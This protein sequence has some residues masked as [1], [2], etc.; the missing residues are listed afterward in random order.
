VLWKALPEQNPTKL[1]STQNTIPTANDDF[2]K[3]NYTQCHFNYYCK[4]I[5]PK[6]AKPMSQARYHN[7]MS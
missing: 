7:K 4:D 5:S 3:I 2:P 6:I 1:D